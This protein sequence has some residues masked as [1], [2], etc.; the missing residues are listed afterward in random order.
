MVCKSYFSEALLKKMLAL[1]FSRTRGKDRVNLDLPTAPF[2]LE[3]KQARDRRHGDPD[4][5]KA[6][7]ILESPSCLILSPG[8]QSLLCLN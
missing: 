4:L 3:D 8:P 5:C 1:S 7:A 2:T 6:S